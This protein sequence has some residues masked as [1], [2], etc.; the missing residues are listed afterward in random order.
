MEKFLLKMAE[1]E[2]KDESKVDEGFDVKEIDD[3][4]VSALVDGSH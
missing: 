2:A 4:K 1:A 3:K